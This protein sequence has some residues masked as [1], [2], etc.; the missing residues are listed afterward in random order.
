MPTGWLRRVAWLG[1]KTCEVHVMMNLVAGLALA[2]WLVP[3]WQIM[4]SAYVALMAVVA[5]SL[6]I[7]QIVPIFAARQPR[8]SSLP[9]T[10]YPRGRLS[11]SSRATGK[12][13]RSKLAQLSWARLR[14]LLPVA[15]M[16][17]RIR[18]CCKA[19]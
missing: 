6:A 7:L 19:C 1:R 3:G 9:G 11:S 18:P 15:A 2:T 13:F 12:R 14:T 16:Q 4:R 5:I 8:A 17:M 10:A